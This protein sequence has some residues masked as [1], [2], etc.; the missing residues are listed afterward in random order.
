M[1]GVLDVDTV[2]ALE[3][4]INSNI[5]QRRYRF[6]HANVISSLRRIFHICLSIGCP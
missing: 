1:D 2:Q 6:D 5:V 4:F 3:P